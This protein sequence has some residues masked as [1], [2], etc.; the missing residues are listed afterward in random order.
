VDALPQAIV[1]AVSAVPQLVFLFDLEK[2]LN[3]FWIH[4]MFAAQVQE[5]LLVL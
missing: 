2:L 3:H 4:T 1:N 5:E